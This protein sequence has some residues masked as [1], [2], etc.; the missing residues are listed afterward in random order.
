MAATIGAMVASMGLISIPLLIIA[1]LPPQIATATNKLGSL[2]MTLVSAYK[3][4]RAGKIQ[5]KF[6]GKFS[7]IAFVGSY[8]GSN[9][10]LKVDD[11]FLEYFIVAIAIVVVPIIIWE[12]HLGIKH[13]KTTKRMKNIGY[14][15]Y[16][17]C[18]IWSG[19]IGAGAGTAIFAIFMSLFGFTMLES[20]ATH[21]IPKLVMTLTALTVFA[22]HG[23]IDYK[24]GLVLF[25]GMSI[26]GYVGS[27]LALQKGNKWVKRIF[28]IV[29]LISALKIVF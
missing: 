25:A 23:I 15:L 21:K 26:G 27:S 9:L 17:F 19:F 20:T 12:K 11:R 14:I 7:A 5:W 29:V 1:G 2:G 18:L 22:Y 28:V 10:L 13:K 4:A 3:F 8:I 16:F 6:A 24:V